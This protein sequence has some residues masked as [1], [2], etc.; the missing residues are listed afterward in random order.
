M[1]DSVLPYGQQPSRPLCPWD[2]LGKNTGVGCHFLLQVLM[3]LSVK[4]CLVLS[5]FLILTILVGVLW[6]LIVVLFVLY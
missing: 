2:S 6:F 1:P 5:L 3:L 4:N